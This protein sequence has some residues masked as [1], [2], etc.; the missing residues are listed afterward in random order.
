M[1]PA[2]ARPSAGPMTERM[3]W[4]QAADGS[5]ARAE[6]LA[7]LADRQTFVSRG[8]A[9]TVRRVGPGRVTGT[10]PHVRG[11]HGAGR[12]GGGTC[13]QASDLRGDQC[14]ASCG[15]RVSRWTSGSPGE[16]GRDAAPASTAGHGST[17]P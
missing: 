14:V 11:C 16:D 15:D 3:A 10:S 4:D 13:G 5:F 9:A 8:I 12:G 6:V 2:H 1:T 7:G 17:T